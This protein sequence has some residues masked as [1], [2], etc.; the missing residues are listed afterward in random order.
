MGYVFKGNQVSGTPL[1]LQL[2]GNRVA[3]AVVSK[4]PFVKQTYYRPSTA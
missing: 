4:M 3:K 1:S 2:R